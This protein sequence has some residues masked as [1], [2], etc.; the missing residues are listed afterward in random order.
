MRSQ[1]FFSMSVFEKGI[2]RLGF[3]VSESAWTSL[4][5]L[6]SWNIITLFYRR[7]INPTANISTNLKPF[8]KGVPA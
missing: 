8:P 5:T 7:R 2:C 6:D 1:N 4:V 3:S